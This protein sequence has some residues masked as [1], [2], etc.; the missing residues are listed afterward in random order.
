MPQWDT[1]PILKKFLVMCNHQAEYADIYKATHLEY[2]RDKA[3]QEKVRYKKRQMDKL[4][5][6]VT[7]I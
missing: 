7:T 4:V 6:K 2:K 1:D 3:R 5:E